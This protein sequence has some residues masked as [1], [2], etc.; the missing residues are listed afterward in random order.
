[1]MNATKEAVLAKQLEQERAYP[2]YIKPLIDKAAASIL[3]ILLLPVIIVVCLFIKLDSRGPVLFKQER[4]GKNQKLFHIYKFRTM[5]AHAPAQGRSPE[6][7]DDPRITRLGK[8]L[9]KTSLDE[10]PQLFNILKG[11]MSFIGPRPEQKAIV[12]Q[13]Y[14]EREMLRFVA[15]PGITGLWQVSSARKDPIH[16]NLHYDFEYI[17]SVS[18]IG[19][20]KILLLTIKVMFISNTY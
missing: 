19:D 14:G 7:S 2:K 12:D 16:E 18:F 8:I 3:L 10:I 4:Y 5:Y 15:T 17:S 6:T 13:Y 1:M 11:E 9:R 20:I